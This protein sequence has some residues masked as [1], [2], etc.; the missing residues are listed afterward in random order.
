MLGWTSEFAAQTREGVDGF[1]Y[2]LGEEPGLPL[3]FLEMKRTVKA[4]GSFLKGKGCSTLSAIFLYLLTEDQ[5]TL[6]RGVRH[7]LRT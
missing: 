2:L 6:P 7:E 1:T 5:G 4:L 3:H